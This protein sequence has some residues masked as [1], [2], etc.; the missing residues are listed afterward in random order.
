MQSVI[1]TLCLPFEIRGASGSYTC[2][3]CGGKRKFNINFQ[4]DV[5]NCPKCGFRGSAFDLWAYYR[6]IHAADRTELCKAVAKD[7]H[8]HTGSAAV[9]ARPKKAVART[10]EKEIDVPPA[11]PAVQDKTFRALLAKLSLSE[12][13]KENLL[14]RGLSKEAVE[15]AGYVS[16]PTIGISQITHGLLSN[17]IRTEGVPGFYKKTQWSFVNYGPGFLIPCR[18]FDGKIHGLQLRTD[19]KT[20]RKLSAGYVPEAAFLKRDNFRHANGTLRKIPRYLTISSY[21]RPG[22]TKGI[23]KP[24]YNPGNGIGNTVIIT[25]GPLKA[26]IIS[27]FTG[28]ASLAVL[29]VNSISYLPSMLSEL[30]K[31]GKN[32]VYTAF[33]MDMYENPHVTKALSNLNAVISHF[34]F[35]YAQLQWDRAYKGLDDYLL[36]QSQQGET[37]K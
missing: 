18:G 20:Y 29:G 16:A 4:K 17:G 23:T 33:D 36:S 19:K 21:G 28:T 12:S 37:G 5:F 35:R 22:G 8:A 15:R 30:R 13:H 1:Q 31:M 14:A 32:L 6:G 7:Y 9:K 27:H 24:H 26:D 3:E 34:G 11:D 25:E 10:V 2:P